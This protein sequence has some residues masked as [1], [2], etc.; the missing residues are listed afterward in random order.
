M[1]AATLAKS[2][3]VLLYNLA[4]GLGLLGA[5]TL[6][7]VSV[8][9]S[10]LLRLDD[11]W[12]GRLA[13]YRLVWGAIQTRPL[14]GFGYGTFELMFPAF[15][16]MSG[17]SSTSWVYAHNSYLETLAGLGIPAG[18]LLWAA[19]LT[20]CFRCA[21]AILKPN[22]DLGAARVAVAT[23]LALGLHSFVDFSIQ[24][25]GVSITA[26]ALLGAG[27]ARAS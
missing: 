11:D 22:R 26:L 23:F 6:V 18:A 25:Q 1:R 5:A 12:E 8:L 4:L 9:E 14:A 20:P 19:I 21:G 7:A 2:R 13:I 16:D 10:R 17:W 3:A 15:R 24:I 27:Y